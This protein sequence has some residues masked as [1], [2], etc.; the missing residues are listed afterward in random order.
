MAACSIAAPAS[1][2]RV[3]RVTLRFPFFKADLII[4][5]LIIPQQTL[6]INLIIT[7]LKVLPTYRVNKQV[8]MVIIHP[9]NVG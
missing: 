8:L 9:E 1:R 7:K 3:L 4:L 6:V 2:S 5:R